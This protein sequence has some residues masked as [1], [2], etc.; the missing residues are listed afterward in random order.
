MSETTTLPG[1]SGGEGNNAQAKIFLVGVGQAQTSSS[2]TS[3]QPAETFILN[4]QDFLDLQKYVLACLAL[5]S[6][7]SL[8]EMEYPAEKLSD[9]LKKEPKLYEVR[10]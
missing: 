2:P 10:G 4:S 9:Y 5:P 3:G 8:F 6:T 1:R 7:A